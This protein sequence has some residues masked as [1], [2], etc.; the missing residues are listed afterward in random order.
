M[1]QDW[2][3]DTRAVLEQP[4]EAIPLSPRLLTGVDLNRLSPSVREFFE[5]R[6]GIREF[7]GNVSRQEAETGAWEDIQ[8]CIHTED[9][10]SFD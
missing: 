8:P 4:E 1:W 10:W 6:A 3:H 9:K 5:E 7:D 2:F